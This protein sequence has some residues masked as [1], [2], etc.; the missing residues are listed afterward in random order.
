MSPCTERKFFLFSLERHQWGKWTT[1]E[2]RIEGGYRFGG[3]RYKAYQ[4]RRCSR[5]HQEEVRVQ[6]SSL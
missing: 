2:K 4:S 6:E 3:T 1:D 5:C